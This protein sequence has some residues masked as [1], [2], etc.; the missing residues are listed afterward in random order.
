MAT[1][2]EVREAIAVQ[3]LAALPDFNVYG[4]V[5]EQ[6][7]A[8]ALIVMSGAKSYEATMGRG[9]HM[10]DFT[11]TAIAGRIDLQSS[12]DLLDS[13]SDGS[14]DHSVAEIVATDP[15]LGGL[16]P[17]TVRVVS[18]GGYAPIAFAGIEYLKADF[19]ISAAF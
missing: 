14:G 17:P 12:Q 2:Q 15:T 16:V 7:V 1:T 18:M 4:F 8:P 9:F 11:I 6:V 3:L 13:L 5:P 19:T 10:H